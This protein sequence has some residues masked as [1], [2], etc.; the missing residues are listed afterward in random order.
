MSRLQ[1]DE[2]HW[3]LENV[4][5]EKFPLYSYIGNSSFLFE[6]IITGIHFGNKKDNQ[7]L[8]KRYFETKSIFR[9]NN[10]SFLNCLLTKFKGIY[11]AISYFCT[12][13]PV[14]CSRLSAQNK[15][16]LLKTFEII[17]KPMALSR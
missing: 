14:A 13:A 9:N 1:Q 10:F 7:K 5:F 17:K 2:D 6:N 16:A 15:S 11:M 12:F 3:N 8:K 4:Y